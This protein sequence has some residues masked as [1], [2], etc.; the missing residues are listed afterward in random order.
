VRRV[1]RWERVAERAEGRVEEL[2][3]EVLSRCRSCGRGVSL[4]EGEE[5]EPE[6]VCMVVSGFRAEGR[7]MSASSFLVG[8]S[9]PSIVPSILLLISSICLSTTF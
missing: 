7:D 3:G 2:N 6:V 8:S 4:V 5:G 9:R 1:V